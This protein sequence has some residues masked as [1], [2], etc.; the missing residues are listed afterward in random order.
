MPA[1]AVVEK[2]VN[3][4]ATPGA[5]SAKKREGMGNRR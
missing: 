1:A 4:F 3:H 5:D 2:P